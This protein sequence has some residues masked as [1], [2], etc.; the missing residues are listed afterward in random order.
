M[1]KKR[2]QRCPYCGSTGVYCD[3]HDAYVCEYCDEWLEPQCKNENC[4]FC[5]G[6]PAHPSQVDLWDYLRGE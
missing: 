4:G 5:A 2:L 1:G 6:R 3:V